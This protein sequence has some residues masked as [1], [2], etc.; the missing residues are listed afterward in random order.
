M[1]GSIVCIKNK[2]YLDISYELDF[3]EINKGFD[4][5]ETMKVSKLRKFHDKENEIVN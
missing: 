4:S 1:T 3:R 5:I 2:I